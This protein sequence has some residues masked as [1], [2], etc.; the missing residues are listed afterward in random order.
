MIFN[1]F[2]HLSHFWAFLLPYLPAP[3]TAPGEAE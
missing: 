2:S 3:E 1:I